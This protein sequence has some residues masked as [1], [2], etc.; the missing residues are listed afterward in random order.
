MSLSTNTQDT[1]GDRSNSYQ[2]FATNRDRA[3]QSEPSVVSR[4]LLRRLAVITCLDTCREVEALLGLRPGDAVLILNSGGLVTEEAAMAVGRSYETSGS[5]EVMIIHHSDCQGLDLGDDGVEN[6]A[7]GQRPAMPTIRFHDLSYLEKK[8]REQMERM[9][10]LSLV[11]QSITIKG[12]IYD[13]RAEK[14]REVPPS[15][16]H[17]GR[18]YYSSHEPT[19]GFAA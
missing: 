16:R 7:S 2:A 5:R 1:A 3:Q 6:P 10:S 9:R 12:F 4:S 11:S 8:V 17:G 14:L 18:S 15:E 19:E 13:V